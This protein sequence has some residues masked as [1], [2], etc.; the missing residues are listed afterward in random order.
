MENEKLKYILAKQ[1]N[2]AAQP[3]QAKASELTLK[4]KYN[5]FNL[6][7]SM[8]IDETFDNF[9]FLASRI[10]E[11]R[12]SQKVR[13]LLLEKDFIKIFLVKNAE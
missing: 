6:A 8:D 13:A 2:A 7:Y 3:V 9:V 12:S 11:Y 1:K 10:E 5:D 4:M